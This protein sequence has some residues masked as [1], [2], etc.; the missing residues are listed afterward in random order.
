MS[1]VAKTLCES[2]PDEPITTADVFALKRKVHPDISPLLGL[3]PEPTDNVIVLYVTDTEE[4]SYLG[5]ERDVAGWTVI[6]EFHIELSPTG[7]TDTDGA[8]PDEMVPT[9]DDMRRV[10]RGTETAMEWAETYYSSETFALL[11]RGR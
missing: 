8:A 1:D 4:A 6:D 10:R 11:Q 3:Q 9:P 5:V 7:G 2:L